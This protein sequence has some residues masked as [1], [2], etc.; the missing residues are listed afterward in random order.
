MKQYEDRSRQ[1]PAIYRRRIGSV[2]VNI[3]SDGELTAAPDMFSAGAEQF[4][5]I[6]QDGFLQPGPFK[7][8]TAVYVLETVDGTYLVDAGSG[9]LFGE[10]S[11][12][13]KENLAAIGIS[14]ADIDGVLLTHMHADHV[15]GLLD[16]SGATFPNAELI[17]HRD[18]FDYY[19]GDL[20]LARSNDRNRPWIM[21]ARTLPEHYAHI[22]L[23]DGIGEVFPGI[24]AFPLP[25]HT[26]GH[27]GY[28][29]QSGDEQLF[30][31]G[32]LVYSQLYSFR[33]LDENFLFDVD[34]DLATQTRRNTLEML[35]DKRWLMTA[36]H[37]AFPALGHVARAGDAFE[38]VPET[39]QFQ[40]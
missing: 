36:S 24:S 35:A 20:V 6:A 19:M 11:G 30:I 13:L 2:L 29:L 15:G 28:L 5:K 27:S 22:R 40:L 23:F 25:G 16:E 18:E 12:L 7:M 17:V 32:D 9:P 8:G 37:L 34:R 33:L 31:A 26:P 14:L 4:N 21:R 10:T 38:W 3:I 39:W 1:V